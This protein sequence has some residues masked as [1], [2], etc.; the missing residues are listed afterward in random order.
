MILCATPFR[1]DM[2]LGRAYNETMELLGEDDWAVFLDHD[3]C[4]TT[5]R[6]HDQVEAAIA[7]VPDAG[8]FTAVTNRIASRWQQAA[9]VQ[10][11]QGSASPVVGHED[12]I[13]W[14]RKV[15]EERLNNR[16]LLDVTDTQGIGGVVLAISKATW[17]RQRFVSGLF[18]VDHNMHF[19]LK[20]LGLRVWLIEGLYVYHWRGSS[21]DANMIR[22]APK[23]E[24]PCRRMRPFEPTERIQC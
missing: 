12:D 20:R 4:W 14:H 5:P 15:G 16:D 10:A 2:D 8:M 6:W 18:C 23:A 1:K 19:A 3:A 22:T 24:C 9:E 7:R 11:R 13:A 21:R 17:R